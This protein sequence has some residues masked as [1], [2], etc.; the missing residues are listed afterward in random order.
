MQEDEYRRNSMELQRR[1]LE[2]GERPE[3]FGS[4]ETGYYTL[5]PDGKPQ[6][7]IPGAAQ[8]PKTPGSVEAALFSADPETRARAEQL[9]AGELAQKGQLSPYQQEMLERQDRRIALAERTASRQAGGVSLGEFER[10]TANLPPEQREQLR[11][12]RAQTLAAGSSGGQDG[13]PLVQVFD[14]ATGTTSY[15]PRSQATG[16]MAPPKSGIEMTTDENGRPVVRVGGSGG[17]KPLPADMVGKAAAVAGGTEDVGEVKKYLF[18]N[19]K[20]DPRAAAKMN[21]PLLGGPAPGTSGGGPA[22]RMDNAIDTIIRLRTGAGLNAQE[23]AYYKGMYQP[24]LTDTEETAKTKVGLLERELNEAQRLFDEAQ[25][26]PAAGGLGRDES[27]LKRTP[28]KLRAP[29]PGAIEDGYRFK[30]GDPKDPAAW[31]P[32]Q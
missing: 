15:A 2:K 31:E 19:D 24:G 10:L 26:K 14:P 27:G 29:E 6:Q 1:K 7:M 18:P 30:G 12:Q 17:G 22:A 28:I 9:R 3:I 32:M 13:E 25:K 11:R 8:A 20:Y 4:G 21:M 23:P 5:G 16:K